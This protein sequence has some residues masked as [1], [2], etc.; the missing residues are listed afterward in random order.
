MTG[1]PDDSDSDLEALLREDPEL[2]RV[3]FKPRLP[4]P[5]SP[6]AALMQ[7]L[8]LM[9]EDILSSDLAAWSK[10]LDE[11]PARH[12]SVLEARFGLRGEP[13]S[14]LQALGTRMGFTREWI[15]Q[16][17]ERGLHRLRR[18]AVQNGLIREAAPDRLSYSWRA[19]YW[20]PGSARG[21]RIR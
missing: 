9:P 4:K 20:P 14:T 17:Q 2:E 5:A 16:I 3:Y 18:F 21:K 7:A 1:S 6:L 11:L 8:K 15:R 19:P 13:R 12:R 10:A